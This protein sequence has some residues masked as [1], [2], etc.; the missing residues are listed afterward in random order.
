MPSRKTSKKSG[1]KSVRKKVNRKKAAKKKASKKKAP[2]KKAPKKSAR[3]SAK[4]RP[5][6]KRPAKKRP[7]KKQTGKKRPAKKKPRKLE[8]KTL[9]QLKRFIQVRGRRRR[10]HTVPRI[11]KW[12]SR[13]SAISNALVWNEPDGTALTY[14]N[15]SASLRKELQHAYEQM[16]EAVENATPY[17]G[18]PEAPPLV[19]VSAQDQFPT[20]GLAETVAREYYMAYAALSI[21]VEIEGWLAWSLADYDDA[22]LY[23]LFNSESFFEWNADTNG[24]VAHWAVHG[25]V[26]PGDPLRTYNF[27]E[28]NALVGGSPR[29]TI[30]RLL[31]WSRD[32]LHHYWGIGPN[33]TVLDYVTHW[34]YE[35]WAPVERMISGTDSGNGNGL[36]HWTAGCSGTTGFLRTLL[37]LVNVP[38]KQTM[39]SGHAAPHFLKD[40]LHLC[41]GDDPYNFFCRST[42]PYAGADMLIDDAQHEAWFGAGV[43]SDESR[44]NVGRR[45]TELTLEILPTKLLRMHC[46]DVEAGVSHQDSS[47]FDYF[48]RYYTMEELESEAL[49]ERMDDKVEGY[50]GCDSIPWP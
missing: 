40:G 23:W 44:R 41:H 50:G 48:D 19:G 28:S 25:K 43:S 14:R 34:Q 49:W 36:V 46:D 29:Q 15:W 42:P 26:T 39:H 18:L 45:I 31:E 4:K 1:K 10:G 33:D 5:A 24:Y 27:L 2:K 8:K 16:Y 47:V 30:E 21:L 38:V 17:E 32:H 22:Q 9:R 11:S 6:K 7:A 37:R 12:I 35:A 13:R 20:A 3:T